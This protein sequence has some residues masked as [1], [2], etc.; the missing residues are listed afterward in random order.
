MTSATSTTNDEIGYL[1]STSSL[2]VFRA[3]EHTSDDV[4]L[5][6]LNQVRR[7]LR[8]PASYKLSPE[9]VTSGARILDLLNDYATVKTT[10]E[11]F[12]GFSVT[13]AIPWTVLDKAIDSVIQTLRDDFPTNVE[14]LKLAENIFAKTGEPLELDEHITVDEF[15]QTFTGPNLR[16]EILGILFTYLALGMQTA[17]GDST[18]QAIERHEKISRLVHASNTCVMFCDRAESLNDL[19]VWL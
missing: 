15:Y 13:V 8:T 3:T 19:L 12:C 9:R 18:L 4:W 11:M 7:S 16:W 5:G 17:E 1:G 14:R 6:P 10:L 2:E